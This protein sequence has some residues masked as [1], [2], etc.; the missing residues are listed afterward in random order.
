ML[1]Y[2]LSKVLCPRTANKIHSD[3]H[4]KEATSICRYITSHLQY[5]L[6]TFICMNT[7]EDRN[8]SST[9]THEPPAIQDGSVI[10]TEN[11]RV[12][13]FAPILHMDKAAFDVLLKLVRP[14][15]FRSH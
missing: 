3:L 15:L 4:P 2:N 14:K 1:N 8:I 11:K 12:A 13:R 5:Q 9:N 6:T 7:S 10:G